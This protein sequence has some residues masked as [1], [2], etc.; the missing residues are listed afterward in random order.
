MT[1]FATNVQK[2]KWGAEVR[3]VFAITR[4][5]HAADPV[6]LAGQLSRQNRSMALAD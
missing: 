5:R 1:R 3:G 4:G 2:E 6:K